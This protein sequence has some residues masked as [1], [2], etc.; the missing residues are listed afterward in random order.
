M[1]LILA[2][3]PF[4]RQFSAF[5]VNLA[6]GVPWFVGYL[7]L[8]IAVHEAGHLVAAKRQKF[9]LYGMKI[10]FLLYDFQERRLRWDSSIHPGGYVSALAPPEAD[11][12]KAYPPVIRGGPTA[13]LL[14]LAFT[15]GWGVLVFAMQAGTT[16]DMM[17]IIGVLLALGV[18]GTGS[19]VYQSQGVASDGWWLHRFHLNS[20]DVE[21]LYALHMIHNLRHLSMAE[22][23]FELIEKLRLMKQPWASHLQALYLECS[24]W[25]YCGN[26]EEACRVADEIMR[27]MHEYQ[28]DA[29]LTAGPAAVAG[30][31]I[32]LHRQDFATSRLLL[33]G[34]EEVP[35]LMFYVKRNESFIA[36]FEGRKQES[37]EL[38]RESCRMVMELKPDIAGRRG[39]TE[40]LERLDPDLRREAEMALGLSSEST[41]ARGV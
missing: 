37:L 30:L 29:N 9:N 31:I 14:F 6:I 39:L 38:M 1:S 16:A 18:A 8:A 40:A 20:P 21:G 27:R 4:S 5:F 17:A 25:H 35:G 32:T 22:V 13:S 19:F 33:S 10:A 34:C 3:F 15:V 36:H 11:F 23:P 41:L 24:Y 2:V 7:I 26:G 28:L 12:R